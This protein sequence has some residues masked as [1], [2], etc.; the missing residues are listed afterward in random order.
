LRRDPFGQVGE[1]GLGE[2]EKGLLQG[3][4]EPEEVIDRADPDSLVMD[5]LGGLAGPV[6]PGEQLRSRVAVFEEGLS[7]FREKRRVPPA[8]L[9][10]FTEEA[11]EKPNLKQAIW[12]VFQ[13]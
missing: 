12:Y 8:K 3:E 10:L 2:L 7:G 13:F 9:V 6:E 11:D 4:R 1:F 5:T